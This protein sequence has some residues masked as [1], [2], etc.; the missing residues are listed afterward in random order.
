MFF[1]Q[2]IEGVRPGSQVKAV[3]WRALGPAAGGTATEII[4]HPGLPHEVTDGTNL[5]EGIVWDTQS[6][7]GESFALPDLARHSHPVYPRLPNI[8]QVDDGAS[9]LVRS[10]QLTSTVCS[11]ARGSAGL[12]AQ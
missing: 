6:Y 8:V 5:S 9:P 4:S 12:P 2:I 3:L 1:P 11:P 10:S 7:S